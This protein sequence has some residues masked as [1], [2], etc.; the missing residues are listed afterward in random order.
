MLQ[1]SIELGKGIAFFGYVTEKLACLALCT[2]A[3]IVA[4]TFWIF[5]AVT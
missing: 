5:V 4:V 1:I 2:W 3:Y